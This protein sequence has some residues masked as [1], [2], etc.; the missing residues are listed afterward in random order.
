[1]NSSYIISDFFPCLS[2]KPCE[3][4]FYLLFI[5]N[6][7]EDIKD[8][9][10]LDSLIDF[11]IE[12]LFYN[13]S[14]QI[15]KD[16]LVPEQYFPKKLL[17]K[18]KSSFLEQLT[19]INEKYNMF[20]DILS[21]YKARYHI[22]NKIHDYNNSS[23]DFEIVDLLSN[24]QIFDT[25]IEPYFKKGYYSLYY[26]SFDECKKCNQ[27]LLYDLLKNKGDNSTLIHARVLFSLGEYQQS[28]Q[29]Y[30][31]LIVDDKEDQDIKSFLSFFFSEIIFNHLSISHS[32]YEALNDYRYLV[33]NFEEY[34]IKPEIQISSNQIMKM[35]FFQSSNL[36]QIQNPIV[37]H[38]EDL[39]DQI[40][41]HQTNYFP[42]KRIRIVFCFF[43]SYLA[44]KILIQNNL[45]LISII[46]DIVKLLK[47]AQPISNIRIRSLTKYELFFVLN[48]KKTEYYQHISLFISCINLMLPLGDSLSIE[49]LNDSFQVDINDTIKFFSRNGCVGISIKPTM[50]HKASFSYSILNKIWVRIQN[51]LKY[52][53]PKAKVAYL[54]YYFLF[55]WIQSFPLTVF[56]EEIGIL[57][58]N[59]LSVV[60]SN[61]LIP[62][63]KSILLLIFGL[64]SKNT[65]DFIKNLMDN[66]NQLFSPISDIDKTNTLPTLSQFISY[67]NS[68]LI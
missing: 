37:S 44:Q 65:D 30:D 54:A 32:C 6:E 53:E 59:S 31:S 9:E 8:I 35:S 20:E 16:E 14:K 7:A 18:Q 4:I 58:F 22:Y 36:I 39:F 34:L 3:I 10:L 50:N 57:I 15:F 26:D 66:S 5:R 51:C 29:F 1:M 67:L 41:K 49:S 33:D 56:S 13:D 19:S 52:Q 62:F 28:F 23:S 55:A 21:F 24:K 27:E 17:K 60:T 46:N 40:I 38:N 2:L 47:I 63:E 43:H 68:H 25:I 61:E 64:S 45:S 11:H 42:N 48:G 12:N